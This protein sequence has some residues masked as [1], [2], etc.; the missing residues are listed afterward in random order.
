[1]RKKLALVLCLF[2][3][4][5]FVTGCGESL[6]FWKKKKEV[7]VVNKKLP[8]FEKLFTR[9]VEMYN[10]GQY[11]DAIQA[12]LFLRENYPQKEKYQSR[13]TLYL[14][15]SHYKLKEYPEAIANYQEFIKLYPTSPDVSYAYFQIGMSYYKQRRTYDRDA[16]FVRKAIKSFKKVLTVAPPGVMINESIRMIA[17]CQRELAMHELFIADFYLRT[18]HYKSAILRYED[19]LRRFYNLKIHDRAHL[20]IAKAYLK[21]KNK[22]AAYRHLSYVAKNFPNSPYGKEAWKLLQKDYK[23]AS[24]NDLPDVTFPKIMPVETAENISPK[25]KKAETSEVKKEEKKKPEK[26]VAKEKS[27][28]IPQEK[29]AKNEKTGAKPQVYFPPVTKTVKAEPEKPMSTKGVEKPTKPS[30]KASK[31]T[32]TSATAEKEKTPVAAPPPPVSSPPKKEAAATSPKPKPEKAKK[33]VPTAAPPVKVTKAGEVNKVPSEKAKEQPE[34]MEEKT[35][36]K[37]KK[38]EEKQIAQKASPAEKTE[39]TAKSSPS[40][41]PEKKVAVKPPESKPKKVEPPVPTAAPPVKVT[42]AEE[43]KKAPSEKA[44]EQSEPIKEKTTV[45]PKKAEEKQVAQKASPAEK[46]ASAPLH[47]TKVVAK[48]PAP[49]P[50]KVEKSVKVA[51]KAEKATPSKSEALP[52]N[53]K[54]LVKTD[55]LPPKKKEGAGSSSLGPVGAIDTRLPIHISS[56]HVEAKQK[57]NSVR[58]YGKVVVTQKD[59]TLKCNDLTAFYMPGGKAIDKI[60]AHG[61]VSITQRNKKATCEKATFYNAAR[62]IVL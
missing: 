12:L 43:M 50:A 41:Q 34:P 38:E 4:V 47:E 48:P 1:M 58:F 26:T 17:F 57:N 52:K 24:I 37:P 7:E 62:K 22:N 54:K 3:I 61:K 49:K 30:E 20:G 15:D 14:A 55:R 2:L 28:S 13:I 59:V 44:K 18:H 36:V 51:Q 19:I 32:L 6:K 25:P 16:T 10:A 9:T 23:V 8:P 53:V 45:K 46:A 31:T 60:V 33:P 56:D 39:T 40:S 42:K 35:T 21:L 5:P 27:A 11:K 29:T